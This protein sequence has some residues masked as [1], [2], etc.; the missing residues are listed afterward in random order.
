MLK[1]LF[2]KI[3]TN[4]SNFSNNEKKELERFIKD[5]IVIKVD[6][7][8]EINSKY[9]IATLKIEKNF[10]VLEDL[11]SPLK[12]VKIELN[13]LNGAFDNDLVLAKG[14]LIQEVKQKQK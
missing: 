1:D 8:Y 13:E 6:E 5:E 12:N 11:I 14:F 10:A 2:I 4:I 9:K 3:Q 7:H